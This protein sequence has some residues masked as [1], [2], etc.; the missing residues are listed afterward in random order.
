MQRIMEWWDN[1]T[2]REQ[3]MLALM[4]FFGLSALFYF[5][6]YRPVT[7][8]YQQSQ[9]RLESS[10]QDYRWLQKQRQTIESLRNKSRGALPALLTLGELEKTVRQQLKEK[11]IEARIEVI[12]SV[13]DQNAGSL[14]IELSGNAVTVMK[15]LEAM[16]NSGHK[17]DLINLENKDNWLSGLVSVK[18]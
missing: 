16:V 8:A 12:D 15:W 7:Q 18:T 11:K 3:A 1:V 5:F 9:Q 13:N 6:A 14:K 2:F 17:I 4:L 10:Y